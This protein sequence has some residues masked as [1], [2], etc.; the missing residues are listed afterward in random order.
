MNNT[1]RKNISDAMKL[2]QKARG[3]LETAKNE[4]EEVYDNLSPEMQFTSRGERI[5][6]NVD[7]LDSI[8]DLIDEIK[9]M[10]DEVTKVTKRAKKGA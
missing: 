9:K 7:S 3:I 4:E 6:D 5:E 8:L 2:I 1:R 10:A